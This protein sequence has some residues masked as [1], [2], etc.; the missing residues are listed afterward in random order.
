LGRVQGA[1][2][3]ELAFLD[4]AKVA[5][6]LSSNQKVELLAG[7]ISIL[8]RSLQK[9]ARIEIITAQKLIEISA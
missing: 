3:S 8:D 2:V 6:V 7:N 5:A 1:A 4:G 9:K